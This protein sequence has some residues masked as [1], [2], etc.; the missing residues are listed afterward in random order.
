MPTI[1]EV[2]AYLPI[3]Y[4]IILGFLK[5]CTGYAQPVFPLK[6]SADHR[7]LVDQKNKP[8]PI[9][10]RTAWFIISQTEEGYKN[11]LDNTI[12]HGH[13]AIEMA[14]ITHWP[15]GNH[16]P[17]NAR[18]DMPFLKRLNG[19]AWDGKLTYDTIATQAPDLLTPNEK[20][21]TYVDDF[22]AYCEAKGIL[23]FMFPGYV[24]YNGEEQGWM[25]ELVANGTKKVKS[26]PTAFERASRYI[27]ICE[28]IMEKP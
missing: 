13:N 27:E 14:V 23:V 3:S 5:F 20:Y 24:G 18:G 9:L 17:F 25:K 6:V 2:K 15:M 8:F 1:K 22:L 21:W 4:F 28:E 26:F 19:I 12:M 16:A 11:F 10:G 7:Y